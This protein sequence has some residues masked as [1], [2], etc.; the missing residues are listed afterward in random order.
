VPAGSTSRYR[1]SYA[2]AFRVPVAIAVVFLGLGVVLGQVLGTRARER[3]PAAR[4]TTGELRAS[5]ERVTLGHR[6]FAELITL[7]PRRSCELAGYVTLLTRNG[8]PVSAREGGSRAGL[9]PVTITATPTAP[10]ALLVAPAWVPHALVL[11]GGVHP[12]V[13]GSSTA[14]PRA[15]VVTPIFSAPDAGGLLGFIRMHGGAL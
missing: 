4:C 8:V 12:L 7:L 5:S 15:P 1:P 13:V 10:L 14:A 2:R 3:A 9:T 6:R 11:P